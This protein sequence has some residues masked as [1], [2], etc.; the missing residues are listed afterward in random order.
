MRRSK[1]EGSV[2]FLCV[3]CALCG[4]RPL[5]CASR[6]PRPD[7]ASP[8]T[9]SRVRAVSRLQPLLPEL[10]PRT[11]RTSR[12]LRSSRRPSAC[13]PS[14]K[15]SSP[16]A[17]RFTNGEK[18]ICEM[19][20]LYLRPQFRGKGLG[21]VLADRIIAEARQI[22]YQRMRLDTVEP[23]M[24]DAVA[25]YRKLGF[26]EI[27]AVLRES[28]RWRSLHGTRDSERHTLGMN[29]R[30]YSY[31][32]LSAAGEFPPGRHFERRTYKR[33]NETVHGTL[34]SRLAG[35]VSSPLRSLCSEQHPSIRPEWLILGAVAAAR[36]QFA[37]PAPR[38]S[39]LLRARHSGRSPAIK[40][41]G[42]SS[43]ACGSLQVGQEPDVLS[44]LL[45]CAR[46][47]RAIHLENQAR[48]WVF[49]APM[50]GH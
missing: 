11:R 4:E 20:R 12:R 30:A 42:A 45:S 32:L 10:R 8:R 37:G 38:P 14:T 16:A 5:P 35:R 31:Y 24:K 21:R 49:A 47:D 25:M 46:G 48:S 39:I 7:R 43:G 2:V 40:L 50:T 17:L 3:P 44:E 23:V 33:G 6:I 41:N 28:D 36:R 22:G 9:L 29:S 34:R 18:D 19:K 13:S 1:S 26:R 27:A 15:A